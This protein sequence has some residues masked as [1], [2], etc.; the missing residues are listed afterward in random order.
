MACDCER[1]AADC[2]HNTV[3]RLEQP[4]ELY[5]VESELPL[6]GRPLDGTRRDGRAPY[7][8]NGSVCLYL[9][10]CLDVLQ[11]LPD[12]SV[13]AVICD[14][15]YGLAGHHPTVIAEVLAAWL[16]GDRA[17]TPSGRGFLGRDW[18]AFVPPPAV[19]EE[20]LRVLK[21]GGH[22]VAFSAPR[23]A[24]LMGLSIRLAGFE[25][26]DM[27]TWN[28]GCLTDDAE[29]LTEHGWKRGIDVQVG[30]RVAQWDHTTGTISLA[31]VEHAYRAPWD[32]PMRVLRNAD[33]DQ[34]LTPN[35][36][37]YHRPRQRRMTDGVRKVWY[38]DTWKV[39]E[40]GTL[41]SWNSVVLPLAGEHDGPGIGGTDYAALLGWVWTEGGFD[42][43]GTGVRITQS[44]V[45]SD[46]VAEIATLMDRLGAHKRYDRERQYKGRAY[47][48]T[49]W[50]FTGDLAKSVRRDLPA[51]RPT[52]EL[53]WQMT[54]LEKRALL[55]AALL[56]DE[57]QQRSRNGDRGAWQ[58]YQ[59]HE[60]DLVW[61][62]TL[63]ALIGKAGKVGMRSN[64]PG[65]AVYLRD[66]ATTEL[67][68]RHLRDT[69]EDYTGEVWCVRVPTGA[70]VAR[71]NGRVFITGN[72]GF[73]KSLNVAKAI[74]SGGG[75]DYTPS[76]R[77]R[78][79]YDHGAGSAMDAG[80]RTWTPS[81]ADAARWEGWGTALKPASEP[82]IVARKPLAGTVAANVLQY[83]TGALNVDACRTPAGQDYRDK[84]ASVVGIAS[85]CNGDTGGVRT[86]AREDSAHA[87]GRWPT[88]VLL[89]H[90]PS[91]DADGQVIGDACADGCVPGCPV[92]EM[93]RQSGVRRAGGDVS[94]N[95][96]SP[97]FTDTYGEIKSRVPYAK[98]RDEGGASRFFPTF[99]YQAK[100]PSAE[101]P[102][103]ADG[104]AWPTVKPLSLMCWLVRL[105]TPPGGVIVDPFAGTGSTLEAAA[106]E[107]FTAIGIE[108]EQDGADLSVQ[109][110]TKPRTGTACD[111]RDGQAD[112]GTRRA[113]PGRPSRRG[114]PG[115]EEP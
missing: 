63:L 5:E 2:A 104:T 79:N 81:S 19:W 35:H 112:A 27:I 52:Y 26:R 109:R 33:T 12:A 49:T 56:G 51:K 76:G 4:P 106:A 18:D 21:P 66:T 69:W 107:G 83:G 29:I 64:R 96:P 7:F 30:E 102:R 90:Q 54:G 77:G 3:E 67:Q 24:D 46:K 114:T 93:D 11:T 65:G 80:K 15:P 22:L 34:V 86:G 39:A 59:K 105:V 99:R 47:T 100:A 108:R 20:C 40:A 111:S 82:I 53:L 71:R 28:Y 6:P 58:F 61:L 85:P 37:V 78:V 60:D 88:N 14:P 97:R 57:S 72:S 98:H 73:P 23:T 115:G 110:L 103:L 87:A 41:S 91:V 101:R 62:Q 94:G 31:A 48:E 8:E 55:N 38:E 44:S 43:S 36:R 1:P 70:F 32:G 75:R 68:A 25:I 17:Y 42:P 9:G 74:E 45:N 92:S 95:E 16:A 84:C 13:D 113:R 89:A 10:D 50:F